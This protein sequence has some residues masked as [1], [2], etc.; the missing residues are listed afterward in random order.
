MMVDAQKLFIEKIISEIKRGC[1]FVPLIGSGISVASGISTGQGLV[2]ELLPQIRTAA[3]GGWH[4]EQPNWRDDDHMSEESRRTWLQD[5]VAKVANVVNNV[6]NTDAKTKLEQLISLKALSASLNWLDAVDFL[7]RADSQ[8][9][10]ARLLPPDSTT[11]DD[12]FNYL[13]DSKHPNLAHSML[14]HL[15]DGLRMK[16]LLT[17]NFDDLIEQAFKQLHSPLQCFPVHLHASLPSPQIVLRTRSLVK[18]HGAGYGLRVD[19]SLNRLPSLDD[20]KAFDGYFSHHTRMPGVLKGDFPLTL[21]HILVMGYS[22]EDR[23]IMTL[24]AYTLRLRP[25]MRVF[26]LSY[27][28]G[29]HQE[30]QNYKLQAKITRKI[31]NSQEP[32]FS[33]RED[34]LKSRVHVEEVSD[35][36]LFLYELYQ[37]LHHAL[38]P[39][40]ASYSA[41][42]RVPGA[43]N[44]EP[45][46]E[47]METAS[48]E[49]QFAKLERKINDGAGVI[50]VTGMHGVTLVASRY[51]ESKRET[52]E[53]LWFDLSRYARFDDF[54]LSLLEAAAA[55]IGRSH[56]VGRTSIGLEDDK[57]RL[58]L[59]RITS[60]SPKP[61]LI[62][63]NG[64][65]GLATCGGWGP[66]NPDA[67]LD[68]ESSKRLSARFWRGLSDLAAPTALPGIRFIVLFR[69]N[70]PTN[71]EHAFLCPPEGQSG[72]IELDT[73]QGVDDNEITNKVLDWLNK[74]DDARVW[75][76]VYALTLFR[77]SRPIAALSSWAMLKA[78]NA[79][80]E[81]PDVDNDLARAEKGDD[82]LSE[83][84]EMQAIR[85]KNGGFVWMYDAVRR[86]IRAEIEAYQPP[87]VELPYQRAIIHQG[88]ADW[89]AKLFRASND[90]LAATESIYHRFSACT[91]S[92]E[93]PSAICSPNTGNSRDM[94]PI[95]LARTS[96][97]EAI[98]I[99]NTSRGA[100]LARGHLD[101]AEALPKAAKHVQKL[102]NKLQMRDPLNKTDLGRTLVMQCVRLVGDLYRRSANFDTALKYYTSE[103]KSFSDDSE[104]LYLQAVCYI[105]LR[106]YGK[107]RE[108]FSKLFEGEK[109]LL[110]LIAVDQEPDERRDAM[111]KAAETWAARQLAQSKI[112]HVVVWITRFMALELLEAQADNMSG[113]PGNRERAQARFRSAEVV[114]T[115]ATTIMRFIEECPFLNRYN[116]KIR[117][118]YGVL[119]GNLNCPCEA[120][121]RLNE[122]AA[123]LEVENTSEHSIGFAII[124]LRRAEVFLRQAEV[125]IQHGSDASHD[126]LRDCSA[127]IE[128]AQSS[129]QIARKQLRGHRSYVWWWT[130]YYELDLVVCNNYHRLELL[131][132]SPSSSVDGD[133][134]DKSPGRVKVLLDEGREFVSCDVFRLARM[135]DLAQK[136]GVCKADMEDASKQLHQMWDFRNSERFDAFPLDERLRHYVET[137]IASLR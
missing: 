106:S 113:G 45:A 20:L 109:E 24:L 89:Y 105:G 58:H 2:R 16:T 71:K 33:L 119:L 27:K 6:V 48:V 126:E 54:R 56:E 100:F 70:E 5:Q 40:G 110:P 61:F 80:H 4:H 14:A 59:E 95:H 128:A 92:A 11:I 52:H 21:K 118:L 90:P 78:P 79:H 7:A 39:A 37:R 120:H 135:I 85:Y 10:L 44:V 94:D 136:Q 55:K 108:C 101:N 35:L 77:R 12:L 112:R 97:I 99:L 30:N 129:L 124:A 84:M 50:P 131:S 66:D 38:P 69:R 51:F 62:F 133:T 74:R 46:N 81:T 67:L 9:N 111:R 31:Y 26:W 19:D 115:A 114:Y 91:V 53:C 29:A 49:R 73:I 86:S 107:A 32:E 83:L 104:Y 18:L 125:I 127:L 36:G 96:A 28:R 65:E 88:L 41:I 103:A 47:G 98:H 75:R 22:G 87:K 64:R 123:Y 116:A 132:A 3:A 8:D 34:D 117:T 68:V 76:F 72:L 1:G 63:V 60:K 130:L 134:K 43:I 57:F 15:A 25:E 13:T 102:L 42:S 93:F 122:A 121:R 23:R 137:I 17:T 82:L